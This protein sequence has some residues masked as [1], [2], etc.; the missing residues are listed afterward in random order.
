MKKRVFK[1][2]FAYWIALIVN[3]IFCIAFGFG[4]YNRII[5]NSLFD[6]Y[7]VL[8]FIIE[9]LS[10]S[11]VL[12]LINKSKLSILTYSISL[13]LIFLIITFG[14]FKKLFLKNFGNDSMDYIMTPIVYSIL[15]GLFFLIIKYR[16]KTDFI[17]L[18]IDEIGRNQN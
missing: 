3:I 8:I 17:Q 13:I 1:Y 16:I 5:I 7:T 12:L 11:S 18:E 10:F 2:K 15:F 9:M 14:I 6:I 4:L